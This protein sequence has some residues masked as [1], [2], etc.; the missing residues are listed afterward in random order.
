MTYR[1]HF[2]FK[3]ATKSISIELAGWKQNP[4]IY[5]KVDG[6]ERDFTFHISLFIG[7]WLTFENF[8]PKNW[9]PFYESETYGRLPTEKE[10][11]ISIHNKTLWWN[12]WTPTDEWSSKTPKYQNGCFHFIEFITGK[13]D[14]TTKEIEHKDF[15]LPYYE[16]NYKIRVFK[17]NAQWKMRRRLFWFLDI[18]ADRYEVK[19]G[20]VKD[21]EWKDVPIPHEGKGENSWD[22]DEDATYSICFGID[23]KLKG[24]NDVALEFWKSTMKDRIRYGGANWLPQKFKKKQIEFIEA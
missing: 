10:I 19:A 18:N 23:K 17:N 5:F 15:I 16:G 8:L 2:W 6:G 21:G 20:Y 4:S 13:S 1:K 24:C 22:C 11:S 7:M 14:Y 3:N 12:F 9:Y